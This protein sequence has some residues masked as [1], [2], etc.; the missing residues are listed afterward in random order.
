MCHDR[1]VRRFR[2][3]RG[4]VSE[5]TITAANKELNAGEVNSKVADSEMP[6][7][8]AMPAGGNADKMA[9]TGIC[10]GGRITGM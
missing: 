9:V 6:A 8:R 10:W 1:T 3:G 7:Y 4:A 2:H 5:L